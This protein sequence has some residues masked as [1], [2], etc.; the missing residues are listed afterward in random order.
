M[1]HRG[2]TWWPA[3]LVVLVTLFLAQPLWR[4]APSAIAQEAPPS[5]APT[6]TESPTLPP[7]PSPT[8]DPSPTVDPVP[9]EEPSSPEASP[10]DVPSPTGTP[11]PTLVP[12]PGPSPTAVPTVPEALPP[13]SHPVP[14]RVRRMLVNADGRTHRGHRRSWRGWEPDPRWGTYG[15]APLDAAAAVLRAKGWSEEKIARTIYA[16]FVVE[17]PATWSDTW[18]APRWTGGYHPHHGQDV[19]CSYGAPLLAVDKGTLRYGENALGGRTVELVRDDGSFWYYAHLKSYVPGLADGAEVGIGAVIGYCGASGDASVPHVHFAYFT[20]DGVAVD[21]M[22]ALVGWLGMAE[23]RLTKDA[24]HP[25]RAAPPPILGR[26]WTLDSIDRLLIPPAEVTATPTVPA[27]G[28]PLDALAIGVAIVMAGTITRRTSIQRESRTRGWTLAWSQRE[29][30]DAGAPP[31]GDQ[32]DGATPGGTGAG[33]GRTEPLRLPTYDA[34][35]WT[36][37]GADR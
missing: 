21:P 13:A 11:A 9:T 34:E 4:S 3:T 33:V 1:R 10:S 27:P 16:P 31:I 5:D 29:P 22:R 2:G 30:V 26:G 19:L 17:G 20:A 12:L 15:T 28:P 35:G 24:K 37:F 25:V 7:D 18:G 14:P 32:I 6:P 36:T 8:G 23:S